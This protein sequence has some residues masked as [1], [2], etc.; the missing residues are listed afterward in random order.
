M[1]Q[2]KLRFQKRGRVR[3]DAHGTFGLG[4][5]E[6]TLKLANDLGVIV[7]RHAGH[8]HT[9]EVVEQKSGVSVHEVEDYK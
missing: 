6:F 4:T 2:V 1:K 8:H 5:A 7:E 3:I 9:H